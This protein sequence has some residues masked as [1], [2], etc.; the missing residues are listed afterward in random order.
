M[1]INTREN[2]YFTD[3]VAINTQ[4][5]NYSTKGM[6]INNV[7]FDIIEN[8]Y[9]GLL[10]ITSSLFCTISLRIQFLCLLGVTSSLHCSILLRYLFMFAGN[11]L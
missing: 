11:Y 10:G 1:A 4:D 2:N 3:W 6:G 5:T 7:L 9:L 8:N